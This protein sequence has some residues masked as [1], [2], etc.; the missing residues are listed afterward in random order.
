MGIV[1]T[2]GLFAK[3]YPLAGREYAGAILP[4]A[5]KRYYGRG[6]VF[7]QSGVFCRLLSGANLEGTCICVAAPVFGR[8]RKARFLDSTGFRSNRSGA[9]ES[10]TRGAKARISL[11]TLWEAA[12]K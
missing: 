4:A 6:K 9:V 12:D 8:F 7:I 2:R 10:V 5:H 11:N 1:T 3:D